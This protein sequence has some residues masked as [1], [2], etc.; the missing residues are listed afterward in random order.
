MKTYGS[1]LALLAALAVLFAA[2]AR[3]ADPPAASPGTP[4]I[5]AALDNTQVTVLDDHAASAIRGEGSEYRYVL[6][7]ILGVNTFD[8]G[9]GLEWTWN[10]LGYRYGAWGGPGWTNGGR[11]DIF[12]APADPMDALFMHHDMTLDD[13]ALVN[14]LKA[15]PNVNVSFW[16]QVYLPSGADITPGSSLPVDKNVWVSGASFLAGRIFLGWRPIPFTE[17]SRREALTGMQVLQLLH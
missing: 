8:Y 2:Q 5:L 16:G 15:L 1:R 3:A 12:V 6:V 7:R 13:A 9:P 4:A 11:T 10:P 14:G 17:Y